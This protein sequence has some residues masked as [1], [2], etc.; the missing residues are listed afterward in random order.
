ME[1]SAMLEDEQ[2][3]TGYLTEQEVAAVQTL[4]K[5]APYAVTG[6][7]RGMF[8]LARHSGGMTF[9]GCRYVYVEQ[10]DECVRADVHKH[11]EAMRRQTTRTAQALLVAEG[12]RLQ[13]DLG[14]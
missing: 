9:Q 11:V 2:E 8:S 4:H 14:V 6:I 10:F 5:K 1:F 12:K 3:R 13:G 7:S